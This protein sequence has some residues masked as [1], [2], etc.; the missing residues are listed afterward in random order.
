MKSEVYHPSHYNCGKI[1]VI[2]FLE[3]QELNFHRANAVKY[4]C[5]AGRK[6]PNEEITDLEKAVWYLKRDIE[7]LKSR[8]EDREKLRPNEMDSGWSEAD[9]V[10]KKKK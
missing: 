4:V 1:E 7:I 6:N 2:E 9:P 8:K 5:R 10:K 3:D